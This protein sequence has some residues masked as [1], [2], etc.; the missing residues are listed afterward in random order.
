MHVSSFHLLLSLGFNLA[1]F[2]GFLK[3]FSGGRGGGYWIDLG[4]C[5]EGE[6]GGR[7]RDSQLIEVF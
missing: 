7:R 2:G 6:L 5:K 1:V 3:P 4:I